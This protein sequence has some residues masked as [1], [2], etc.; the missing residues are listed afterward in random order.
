MFRLN[1]IDLDFLNSLLNLP[2]L[3]YV[4]APLPEDK[5]FTSETVANLFLAHFKPSSYQVAFSKIHSHSE[6]RSNCM[7]QNINLLVIILTLFV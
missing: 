7:Y 4:L 5:P 2:S 6:E 1:V 3:I